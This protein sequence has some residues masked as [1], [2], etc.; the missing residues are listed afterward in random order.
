MGGFQAIFNAQSGLRSAQSALDT[1]GHNISNA[2]TPGYSRQIVELGSNAG[3]DKGTGFIGTGV[4]VLNVD[5]QVDDF[6]E[7]RLRGSLGKQAYLDEI[8]TAYDKVE[9]HFNELSETDLSSNLNE[10]WSS[11][12]ELESKAEDT[13]SRIAVLNET[14]TMISGMNQLIRNLDE[15]SDDLDSDI[16]S[17]VDSVNG[18]TK[19]IADLNVKIMTVEAGGTRTQEANDLRD[20]R[21]EKAKELYKLTGGTGI[22]DASGSLNISVRGHYA[23]FRGKD[24][25]LTT[26]ETGSNRKLTP[27]F[28]DGGEFNPN[29]GQIGG[30]L[31]GR[32]NVVNEYQDDINQ[33]SAS[34]IWEFNKIHS[35]GRGLEGYSEIVSEQQVDNTTKSLDEVQLNFEPETPKWKV[36]NGSF[37][38]VVRTESGAVADKVETIAVDLDNRMSLTPSTLL[39]D[40]KNLASPPKDIDITDTDGNSYTVTVDSSFN[41]IQ[42]I[43]NAINKVSSGAADT[44][45]RLEASIDN[46]SGENRLVIHDKID[47]G[48]NISV[49]DEYGIFNSNSGVVVGNGQDFK[50]RDVTDDLPLDNDMSLDQLAGILNSV[51]HINAKVSAQRKLEITSDDGYTFSFAND[52]SSVLAYLGVATYFTGYNANTMALNKSVENNSNLFAA[53]RL[54]KRNEENA[55]GVDDFAE[56]DNKNLQ[57]LLGLRDLKLMQGDSMSFEQFHESTV[58]SVALGTSRAEDKLSAQTLEVTNLEFE[59][60]QISGVSLDE[61]ATQMMMFQRS[62]QAAARMISTMDEVFQTLLAM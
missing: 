13:G 60:D 42:D 6:L 17:S 51:D 46:S 52:S 10:F 37:D 24:F 44:A 27:I 21:D 16:S 53:A 4:D 31:Y 55:P 28:E 12:H 18:L 30:F 25:P 36:D 19:A 58:S 22:E 26:T 48:G 40:M 57:D 11:L 47:G 29:D 45:G 34:L 39:S 5:R 15:I 38:I 32:D 59:R 9:L 33:L 20:Y 56:A 14:Q 7:E 61:E 35:N 62:Y 8:A 50:G 43:V 23:V 2:S 49:D 1:I 54:S 41:N 3:I